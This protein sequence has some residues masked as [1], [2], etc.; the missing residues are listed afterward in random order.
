MKRD[1]E[2]IRK[3]VLLIED[4]SKGWAPANMVIEGYS[5]AQIGYH[6]YLLVDSGLAEGSDVTNSGSEAPEYLLTHLTSAGHDFA[7]SAR[8]PY[9]WDEVMN[10]MRN[11]GI[12][13]AALDV[14]KRSLDS[15]IRKQLEGD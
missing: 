8:T 15:R 12:L 3:I 4:S 6:A 9:I 10:D 5:Q 2:L 14:I 13:S 7:D 1:M 11:K